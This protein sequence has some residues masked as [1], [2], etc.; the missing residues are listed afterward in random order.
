MGFTSNRDFAERQ[1]STGAEWTSYFHKTGSPILPA[2]GMC[3]DLSMAA[4]TPKYNAYVGTQGEGTPLV[5]S[6]NFGLFAPLVSGTSTLH[7]TDIDIGTPSATFAPATF[8]LCDYLYFYPLIDFDSTD[9]Q[10]MDNGVLLDE[11]GPLPRYADGE[12]VR[13]MIVTTT[14]QTAVAQVNIVYTNSAGVSGRT[15]TVW[16]TIS[17]VG[18]IQSANASSGA[19][20]S[21]SLFIP[22]AAGDTGIRYIESVTLLSS[23]GG[24]AAVVLV[25]PLAEIKLREQ[26]TVAEVSYLINKRTLPRVLSGAYLNF[27]F[28]SGAAAVTSVI[29]GFVRFA[30]ST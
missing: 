3:G 16:T 21:Q 20:T 12:G 17:N 4:G 9:L 8:Y 29:R 26:N 25:K 14:P 28:Q 22:L 2:A 10:T 1:Y 24:F 23:A 7:V 15:T 5:G 6:G 18:N 27:V 19:A 30:W 13:A 11:Q